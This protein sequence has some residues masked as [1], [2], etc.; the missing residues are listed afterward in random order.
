VRRPEATVATADHNVPTINRENIADEQ[1][2][3]QVETLAKKYKRT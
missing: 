1:S 3:I 2:R